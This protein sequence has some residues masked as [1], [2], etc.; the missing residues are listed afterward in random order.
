MKFNYSQPHNIKDFLPEENIALREHL[1]EKEHRRQKFESIKTNNKKPIK[2]SGIYTIYNKFKPVAVVR[3]ENFASNI[4]EDLYKYKPR[5]TQNFSEVDENWFA[6]FQKDTLIGY[7][8]NL[9][10]AASILEGEFNPHRIKEYTI[11]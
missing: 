5:P 10:Q 2:M 3:G 7:F 8:S 4:K 9:E 1:T 6:I 11:N